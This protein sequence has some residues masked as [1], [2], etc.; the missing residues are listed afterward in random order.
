MLHSI[1]RCMSAINFKGR[2]IFATLLLCM[3]PRVTFIFIIIWKGYL[4]PH[5]RNCF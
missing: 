5:L 2:S 1:Y 3:G 4:H